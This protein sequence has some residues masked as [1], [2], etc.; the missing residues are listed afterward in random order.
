[1]EN[2]YNPKLTPNALYNGFVYHKR[3]LPFTHEFRYPTFALFC[4]WQSLD[5]NCLKFFSYNKFNLF[6]LFDKDHGKRDGSSVRGWI[7]H[8]AQKHN[9]NDYQIYFLGYPRILGFV[10]NPLSIFFL[11]DSENTLRA[12]VYEVKNTFGHQH[13]YFRLIDGYSPQTAEKNFHVSPFFSLDCAYEFLW[14]QYP[15]SEKFKFTI[16]Q[17]EHNE[18]AFMA[19]WDGMRH[20]LTDKNLFINFI[21]YPFLTLGVVFAIHW[22]ALKIWIKGGRYHPV[23][24][25]PVDDFS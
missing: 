22:Q 13:S 10:F 17:T 24:K 11:I 2:D 19:V 7:D 12:I 1:M 25:P 4:N 14:D 6:S 23:P 15:P 9:L 16:K 21:Q 8:E 18:K 5:S 3:F 20:D